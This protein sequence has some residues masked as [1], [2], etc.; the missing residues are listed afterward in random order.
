LKFIGFNLD[1]LEFA[2]FPKF[3]LSFTGVVDKLGFLIIDSF[4]FLDLSSSDD[5]LEL[6][7]VIG[8]LLFF[9]LFLVSSSES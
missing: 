9:F 4:L 6:S 1:K 3:V 2:L 5:S 8:F 7:F